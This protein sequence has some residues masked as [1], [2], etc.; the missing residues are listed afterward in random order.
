MRVLLDT[1]ILLRFLDRSDP[2]HPAIRQ[3]FRTFRS[4]GDVPVTA[5][6]NIAEFWNV[7]TR[8]PSARG[9]YGLYL[10]ETERR[11][12]L[13]ERLLPVLTETPGSYTFWRHLVVAQAVQGVQAH[14]ARLVSLM[15]VHGVSHLLTLNPADF[16]RYQGL[17]TVLSP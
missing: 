7:C 3:A 4:Q 16:G 15:Q 2:V 14:D 8:P 6:Q 9:G 13:L 12:H 1:G 5:F 17:I 10:A 11:V